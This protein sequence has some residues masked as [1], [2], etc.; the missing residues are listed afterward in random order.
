MSHATTVTPTSRT[1]EVPGA[2][3]HYEVRG[4]GPCVLLVGAPMDATAFAPLADLLAADHTVVTTDPRGIH[5]STVDDPDQDST[6]EQ[7]ADDLNRLLAHVDAGPAVALGSSGGAVSV[8]ALTQAH[9][10]RVHTV[11]AH[12][13]P[14]YEVL[15]DRDQLGAQS[16]EMIASYLAGDVR[17]AWTQF[18]AAANIELPPPLFEAMFGTPREGQAAADERFQFEHMLR[19]TTRWVPD[20]TALRGAPTRIVVGIGEQSGGQLCDRASRALAAGLG[21]EP[22]LF[23]GGHTGFAEEPDAFAA[24][25][26]AVLG[27][28][29]A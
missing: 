6:P 13:P 16:E 26:R 15:E 4:T 18:M 23:P 28:T 1:L 3:L 17:G 2:R 20:V 5:R 12:E 8:L 29:P 24:R 11:I 27:V 19:P 21:S 22:A 9:P 25:L 10:G 7:R 14:L